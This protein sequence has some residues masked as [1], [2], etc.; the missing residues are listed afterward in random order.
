MGEDAFKNEFVSLKDRL[1][2][3]KYQKSGLTDA[4]SKELKESLI[5]LLIEDKIYKKNDINLEKLAQKL[6]TTRHN[7]SQIINEHF[8]M[9]FT[10]LNLVLKRIA[11]WYFVFPY[12]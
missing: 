12:R 10:D 6:N 9:N 3:E 8:E 2:S 11:V 4:L 7:A 1:F 5:S